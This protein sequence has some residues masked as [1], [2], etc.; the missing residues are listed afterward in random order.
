VPKVEGQVSFDRPF[1]CWYGERGIVNAIVS[2]VAASPR[3][4]VPALL[5]AVQ[6]AGGMTPA[7]VPDIHNST[8]FVEWGLA[9]FGNPDLVVVSETPDGP[10]CVFL[11]AKVGPYLSSMMPTRRA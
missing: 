1:L 6:W 11:E 2:H 7:W 9:D 3:E 10:R 5:Q 4:R 8:F